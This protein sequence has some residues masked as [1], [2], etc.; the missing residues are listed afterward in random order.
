MMETKVQKEKAKHYGIKSALNSFVVW[1]VCKWDWMIY[2]FAYGTMRRMCERD[3]AFA[4]ILERWIQE[5]RSK[6]PM[7]ETLENS[8]NSFFESCRDY[9][10][11]EGF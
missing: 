9:S 1:L 4:L 2:G 8:A 3:P 7:S 11:K 6:N 10:E 5:W